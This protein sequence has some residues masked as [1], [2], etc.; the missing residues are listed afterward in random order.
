MGWDRIKMN[1]VSLILLIGKGE[2][3]NR[4][5]KRGRNR[6]R[7]EIICYKLHGDRFEKYYINTGRYG[8]GKSKAKNTRHYAKRFTN[9]KHNSGWIG[10]REFL[11][12]V[13][14]LEK[15]TDYAGINTN[16]KM[17]FDFAQKVLLV[18]T[19]QG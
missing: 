7:E 16:G 14:E 8:N 2:N 11:R 19:T 4:R 13:K 1:F 18:H 10:K 15:N 3:N 5:G 9:I 17:K 6:K 12:E